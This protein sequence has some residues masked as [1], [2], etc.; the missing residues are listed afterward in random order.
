MP[1]EKAA[2]AALRPPVGADDPRRHAITCG[3]ENVEHFKARLKDELPEAWE[4]AKELY[5]AGLMDGL[6]G[7]RL[8]PVGSLKHSGVTP[9]IPWSVERR[10]AASHAAQKGKK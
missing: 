6:R 1:E 4:L 5:K 7:A 9:Y 10:L 3:P 2:H 8:G